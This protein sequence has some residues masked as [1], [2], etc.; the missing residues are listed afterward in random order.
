[1]NAE[2]RP[3]LY[4]YWESVSSC[5]DR[6]DVPVQKTLYSILTAEHVEKLGRSSATKLYCGTAGVPTLALRCVGVCHLVYY[7]FDI[8]VI[9]RLNSKFVCRKSDIRGRIWT[10][11]E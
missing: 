6:S 2:T 10:E 5:R 8:Y 4:V 3:I 11:P 9:N 1:M 7:L